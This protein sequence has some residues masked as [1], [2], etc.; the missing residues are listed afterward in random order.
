MQ[1]G[2]VGLGQDGRQHGPPDP[3]RLGSRGRGLRLRRGGRQRGGGP[4]RDGRATSLEDLVAKLETPRTVWLMVPA[5]EPTQRRSRSSP[6]CSTRATR[7]STAATRSGRDDKRRRRGARRHGHRLRR[8]RHERRRVGP[9][10]G[11]LHDGRRRR[12]GGRAAR[13]DPRRA[14]AA[15]RLAAAWARPRRRPL[16]EDGPQR[17]GVRDDAG[18]R[19]GL[20]RSCTPPSTSSTSPR[21]PTS[22][23]RARWCARG[24]CEL[25][26]RAFEQEGNDLDGDPRLRR[27]LGRGPLDGRSTRSTSASRRR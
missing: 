16:R 10:G 4:R 23:T 5:G 15:R 13:A 1:I 8:R 22:G 6:G 26:E 17:R 9:R 25:A 2:F 19:R 14:R 3:A 24:C 20:R 12:R 27:G 7:S 11:L 18:L 21:S